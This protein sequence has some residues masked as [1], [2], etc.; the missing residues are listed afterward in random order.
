MS[1]KDREKNRKHQQAWRSR[2]RGESRKEFD[3]ERYKRNKAA[4]LRRSK[5]WAKANP[6]HAQASTHNTSVRKRYPE[7]YASTD[8]TVEA[9]RDWLKL[10]RNT[11][12]RYCLEPATYIDHV[13]PL[14]AGGQHV[15]ANIQILCEFCNMAKNNFSEK[16][17]LDR[18]AKI[19]L[20]LGNQSV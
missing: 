15:W 7:Q 6:E 14:S 9:L 17:F 2:L 19:S 12:C 13:I 5:A 20:N 1:T 11:P 16:E 18:V 4:Y 8:I 3:R 10:K